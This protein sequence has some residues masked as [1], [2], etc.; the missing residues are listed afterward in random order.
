MNIFKNLLMATAGAVFVALGTVGSAQAVTLVAP[1]AQ[2]GNS[3]AYVPFNDGAIANRY[4]QVYA[5]GEFNSLSEPQVIIRISFR[6]D[7]DAGNPFTSNRPNIQIN[8]STTNSAP[9][10]L[11]IS[12]NI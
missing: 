12:E 5:S 1:D 4:Q 2:E 10:D 7:A 3:S 8:L 6:P 9:D 11:I